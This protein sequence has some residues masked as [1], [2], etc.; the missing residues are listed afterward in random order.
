MS[1]WVGCSRRRLTYTGRLT[2]TPFL[3]WTESP[4]GQVVVAAAAARIRFALF[5]KARAARRRVWS[6]L[7]TAARD[8]DVIGVIQREVDM[9][10]GRMSDLAL[11]AGL[12]CAAIELH[13]LVVV[14]SVLVNGA[15]YRSLAKH[16]GAQPAVASLEAPL[17]AF[18]VARLIEEI[19]AAV[20]RAQPSLKSPLPAGSAWICVGLN[21]AFL[22]HIPFQGRPWAG[23]HYVLELTRQSITRTTRKAVA[24]KI[25]SFEASLP[26]LSRLERNEI[27]RNAETTT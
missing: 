18:F 20:A 2:R 13:R 16:L 19:D 5:G 4:E 1:A 25:R 23:H 27:L 7:A 9:Y 6:A 21:R 3:T 26:L 22:W 11:G 17:R 10:L 12:P 14:P 8:E 15:A 24:E